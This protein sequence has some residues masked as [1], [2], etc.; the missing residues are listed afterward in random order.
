VKRWADIPGDGGSGVVA[1]VV[2]HRR[3]IAAALAGVRHLV[4]VASGKGGVGKSTVT[5]ALAQC[6]VASGKRVAILDADLNGPC[7]AAMAGLEGVPWVPGETGVEVPRRA[8]GLGV[9]SLGSLLPPGEA[10]R[11]GTV[12]R[13]DE[14]VWRGTREATFLGQV[15]AAVR[16]GELDALLVDLPPGPERTAQLAGLLGPRAGFVLVTIPSAVARRVVAR[17]VDALARAGAHTL[18]YVENMAGYACAGC[19]EVRPLFPPGEALPLPCLGGIPFDPEL[20]ALCDAGWPA[21][22]GA[23]GPSPAVAAA[24]EAARAVIAAL[25]SV[26]V[27]R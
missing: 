4:A 7:Q 24:G 15:L 14:Q 20:A 2:E 17:S 11:F 16:W 26:E 18:G 22:A 23:G 3:A 8:D 25:D 13:G 6:L 21:G 5:M 12:S 9:V 10:L 1:Q 27:N 19:G